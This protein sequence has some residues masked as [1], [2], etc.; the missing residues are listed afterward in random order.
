MV[1]CIKWTYLGSLGIGQIRSAASAFRALEKPVPQQVHVQTSLP[2]MPNGRLCVE[3]VSVCNLHKLS[4]VWVCVD[5]VRINTIGRWQWWEISLFVHSMQNY[6]TLDRPWS[7][8]DTAH[9]TSLACEPDTSKC[10]THRTNVFCAF[11]AAWRHSARGGTLCTPRPRSRI[12]FV[13]I[14]TQFAWVRVYG[15]MCPA[16][17]ARHQHSHKNHIFTLSYFVSVFRA[18]RF[19]V[20]S[21]VPPNWPTHP[22]LLSA[23]IERGF[24]KILY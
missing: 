7:N 14:Q 1:K 12:L 3:Y 15:L 21:P 4:I 10:A 6:S 13:A 9:I 23:N 24:M 16:H 20:L 19:T 17:S 5:G 8:N 22:Q 2:Y 18:Q 11:W